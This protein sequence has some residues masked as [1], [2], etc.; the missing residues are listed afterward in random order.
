MSVETASTVHLQTYRHFKEQA[1]IDYA[2]ENNLPVAEVREAQGDTSWD[3]WRDAVILA[4]KGGYR[5]TQIWINATR[6]QNPE[7]WERRVVHDNP[8]W[9]DAMTRMG[10]SLLFTKTVSGIQTWKRLP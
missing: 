2:T 1:A 5:P 4:I 6:M 10:R 3:E 7:W 8:D 9:C